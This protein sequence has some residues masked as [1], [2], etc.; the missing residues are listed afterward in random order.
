MFTDSVQK[1]GCYNTGSVTFA[2]FVWTRILESVPNPIIKW[3]DN[4]QYVRGSRKI[5]IEKQGELF[6]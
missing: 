6:P 5:V 4:N 1:D 2:W 3:I